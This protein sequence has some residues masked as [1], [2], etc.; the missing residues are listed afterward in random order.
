MGGQKREVHP[1][2][3]SWVQVDLLG[4]ILFCMLLLSWHYPKVSID[5][6]TTLE[7]DMQK[8]CQNMHAFSFILGGGHNF[9]TFQNHTN[10]LLH[11]QV[12]VVQRTYWQMQL[13]NHH[14]TNT[15]MLS[16]EPHFLGPMCCYVRV[17]KT[18]N[19]P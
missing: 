8:I 16:Q 12:V 1:F 17:H 13:N 5:G 15:Q 7:I 9:L 11:T 2:M 10:I 19:T 3:S 18:L 6:I 14:Q 4:S